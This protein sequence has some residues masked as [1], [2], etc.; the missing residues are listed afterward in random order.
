MPTTTMHKSLSPG[1]LGKYFCNV[2][3]SICGPSE[4]NLRHVT[5]LV[6]GILRQ[7]LDFGKNCTSLAYTCTL[8]KYCTKK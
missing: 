7:F 1:R 5:L 4:G 2:A 6:P 3:P 8:C